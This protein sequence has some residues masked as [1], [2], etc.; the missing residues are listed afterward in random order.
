MQVKKNTNNLHQLIDQIIA[1]SKE[2][3]WEQFYTPKDMSLALV[4][5]VGELIEHFKWHTGKET[6]DYLKKH[7]SEIADELS[8]V[9]FWILLMS[10]QFGVDIEKAFSKK[11][12]K[13][14]NKYP[15]KL[16]KGKHS[17]RP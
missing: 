14:A 12:V 7:K 16:F 6:E 13:N 8:D 4:A 1:F 2:R 17:N 15:I 5:E 9:F 11:M 3:D 10:H